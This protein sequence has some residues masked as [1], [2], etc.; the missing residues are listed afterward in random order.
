MFFNEDHQYFRSLVA[1]THMEPCSAQFSGP[2]H[3]KHVG[4]RK[5]KP[6]ILCYILLSTYFESLDVQPSILIFV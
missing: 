6:F 2:C 1:L 5:T 4:I 3:S